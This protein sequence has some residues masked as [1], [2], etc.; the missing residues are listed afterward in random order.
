M[1]ERRTQ[2]LHQLLKRLGQAVH[3]SVVE[4]DEV[5]ACLHEMHALGWNGVMLLE[6]S[7]A[8]LESEGVATEEASVH[9]H[10]DASAAKVSYQIDARDAEILASLGISPT[11]HRSSPRMRPRET[12]DEP[13]R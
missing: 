5:Q 8:C 1:E 11:R 12:D 3:G 4:S 9:I 6:A 10:V 13:D 2:K 7:L